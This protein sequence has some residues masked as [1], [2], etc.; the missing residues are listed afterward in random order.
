MLYDFASDGYFV[1]V[2]VQLVQGFDFAHFL[3][4]LSLGEETV[5]FD[6]FRHEVQAPFGDGVAVGVG[7]KL[8][9]D[10]GEGGAF[11]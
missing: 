9:G 2:V 8:A 4:D 11:V 5:P 3:S 7:A 10:S 1:A 6:E